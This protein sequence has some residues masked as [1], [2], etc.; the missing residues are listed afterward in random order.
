M[1]LLARYSCN[2][3]LVDDEL[4][5]RSVRQFCVALAFGLALFA[6]AGL[7]GLRT[8]QLASLA[9]PEPAPCCVTVSGG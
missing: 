8:P 5:F 6:A 3:A 1:G 2:D 7:F 9:A 4:Q